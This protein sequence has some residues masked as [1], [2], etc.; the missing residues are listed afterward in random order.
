MRVVR[1]AAGQ[2]SFSRRGAVVVEDRALQASAG[3]GRL[4]L[5]KAG[6]A[7]TPTGT[8]SAEPILPAILVQRFF[9]R[10]EAAEVRGAHLLRYEFV[11]NPNCIR[12]CT[13]RASIQRM[14]PLRSSD[15]PDY[16]LL[17][18]DGGSGRHP[19]AARCRRCD[20]SDA[21]PRPR[22][23]M[24]RLRSW[25]HASAIQGSTPCA[26]KAAGRSWNRRVRRADGPHNGAA[27]RRYR[28]PAH[29]DPAAPALLRSDGDNSEACG[30][31]CPLA[32]RSANW[33][34]RR[35]LFERMTSVGFRTLREL[36]VPTCSEWALGDG[37]FPEASRRGPWDPGC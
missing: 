28:D 7:I 37:P 23:R 31:I 15:G 25:W 9:F 5:R 36:T 20:H 30:P 24:T 29:L 19:I 1:S 18:A 3:S 10:A 6:P 35:E 27:V 33:L 22:P 11:I 26:S 8:L 2:R 16:H 4:I 12:D 32:L 21:R 13:R 17:D 34:T 14:E